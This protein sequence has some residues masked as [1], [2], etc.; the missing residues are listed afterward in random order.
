M[1]CLFCGWGSNQIAALQVTSSVHLLL[2]LRSALM[3]RTQNCERKQHSLPVLLLSL[4][5]PV[6]ISTHCTISDAEY[7]GLSSFTL[8]NKQ[9]IFFAVCIVTLS[10][11]NW[12]WIIHMPTSD[13]KCV[14]SFPSICK[15]FFPSF[16]VLICG[17]GNKFNLPHWE[18]KPES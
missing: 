6:P 17:G 9:L 14:T 12:I 10:L 11:S 7:R 3:P 5:L 2:K 13:M 1:N 15:I 18:S 8:R 16:I 4:R